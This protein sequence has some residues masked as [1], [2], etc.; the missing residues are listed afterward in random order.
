[1]IIRLQSFLNWARCQKSADPLLFHFSVVAYKDMIARADDRATT[2]AHEIYRRYVDPDRGACRFVDRECAVEVGRR[3]AASP[4][5][6]AASVDSTLFDDCLHYVNIYLQ[7]LHAAF[8]IS[9]AFVDL[10]N[11][12]NATLHSDSSEPRPST[13]TAE[14]QSC[15]QTSTRVGSDVTSAR[16]VQRLT[17]EVLVRSQAERER[18]LGQR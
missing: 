12:F 3:L 6:A 1:M 7:R 10:L 2:L 9:D 4:S 18:L 17:H 16:G 14:S 5:S 11:R 8:M 15:G 13:S